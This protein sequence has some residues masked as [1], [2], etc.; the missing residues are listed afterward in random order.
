MKLSTTTFALANAS[1]LFANPL[2]VNDNQTSTLSRDDYYGHLA[3]KD[4]PHSPLDRVF[5]RQGHYSPTGA[6]L[7]SLFQPCVDGRYVNKPHPEHCD[8]LTHGSCCNKDGICGYGSSFCGSG[9]CI[10]QCDATAMCGKYSLGGSIKCGMNICC[11]GTGWCGTTENYCSS[12]PNDPQDGCQSDFGSCSVVPKWSCG[13]GSGTSAKRTI[14]YYQ[15][16]NVRDRVCNKISP[17]QIVSTGYTHLYFAFASID[18]SSFGIVPASADDLSLYKE[19]TSLQNNNLET[20]IAVGGFDFSN[21]GSIWSTMTSTSSNRQAFIQSLITFMQDYGFQGV[22]LD[23]EYPVDSARGGNPS[24]T[25]NFVSLVSDMHAA[26]GGKYG[27]S[28]TLAPDYWY[29]RDFDAIEMQPYVSWFGFMAYDLHG[30][31]DVKTPALG[32]IVRGQANITDIENDMAPLWFDGLDPSKIN[33]SLT[34]SRL[35]L[36]DSYYF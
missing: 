32:N 26:F 19:F 1:L 17:S 10:S 2:R 28:V 29:L 20:W 12:P 7:C 33:V 13:S 15:A 16:S 6:L 22:D 11:S 21:S 23:W 25:Q 35:Q 30:S 27:I 4:G 31:W 3:A 24:D 14:G 9:V 5:K 8:L 36:F 34:L 18:A